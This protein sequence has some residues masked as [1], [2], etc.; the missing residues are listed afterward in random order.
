[1]LDLKQ[2]Q[3]QIVELCN[4]HM[5]LLF[6]S[7]AR[8]TAGENSDVDLCVVASTPNKRELLSELYF[9]VEFERPLDILLYTPEEWAGSIA[10]PHSF[11]H[12]LDREGVLLYG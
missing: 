12:K 1:M 6:G 4:P 9:N 5:I 2:V 10:D 7:Q 3:Q 11:A 8:G